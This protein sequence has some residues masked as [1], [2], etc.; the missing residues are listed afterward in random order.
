[1]DRVTAARMGL[2][3]VGASDAQRTTFYEHLVAHGV[4]WQAALAAGFRP[5]VVYDRRRAAAHPGI[6]AAAAPE[7]GRFRSMFH[8]GMGCLAFFSGHAR[9]WCSRW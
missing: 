8:P 6:L 9:R 1:M 5:E 3:P 4:F 7:R 2:E